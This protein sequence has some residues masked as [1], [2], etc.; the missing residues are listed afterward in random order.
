MYTHNDIQYIQHFSF[1]S[2]LSSTCTHKRYSPQGSDNLLAMVAIRAIFLRLSPIFR[3]DPTV[4]RVFEQQLPLLLG[5]QASQHPYNA[6]YTIRILIGNLLIPIT[7]RAQHSRF[8]RR[9]PTCQEICSRRE[10]KK[11]HARTMWLR[12]WNGV[13][14]VRFADKLFFRSFQHGIFP[15]V[16]LDDRPIIRLKY[17]SLRR[18]EFGK[19][20]FQRIIVGR[21]GEV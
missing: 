8:N 10:E 15:L 4:S 20:T 3:L 18:L 17:K 12:K 19:E 13:G 21:W 7:G 11:W 14:G 2:F 9:S 16:D 6:R 5:T 1:I